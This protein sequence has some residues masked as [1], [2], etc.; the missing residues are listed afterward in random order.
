MSPKFG[1]FHVFVK[2]S[3]FLPCGLFRKANA[4][5]IV[6][7]YSGWKIILFRAEN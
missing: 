6:F 7:K 3:S 2:I 4:E 1:F 5:K